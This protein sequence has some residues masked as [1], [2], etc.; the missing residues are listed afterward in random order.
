MSAESYAREVD[1]SGKVTDEV[2]E[3]L[4]NVQVFAFRIRND[5]DFRAPLPHFV[6]DQS[7]PG[8]GRDKFA[9]LSGLAS[10]VVDRFHNLPSLFAAR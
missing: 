6:S 8:M 3:K 1:S 9:V 5:H 4:R 7:S 10:I 2:H